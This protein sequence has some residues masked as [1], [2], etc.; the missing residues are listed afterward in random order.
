MSLRKP[1]Y[2]LAG[3]RSE[4]PRSMSLVMQAISSDIGKPKPEIAYVGVASFGDNW[5]FY[6]MIA[7]ML[8][9]ACRCQVKRVK[10][11]QKNADLELARKNLLAADAV[12]MSG[13]DM[14]AG[15]KILVEKNLT[16]FFRDLYHQGKLFFGASAGSIMLANEWIRWKNPDDESSAELFPCLGIAPLICDTHAEEDK[17]VELKSALRLKGEGAIGFGIPAGACLRVHP[18]GQLEA[19]GRKVVRYGLFQGKVKSQGN[20][21]PVAQ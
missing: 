1:V 12:F 5:G 19:L 9:S 16:G 4:G 15:M 17:W 8:H 6:K 11:V 3:G 10:I 7:G 20:L 2:L 18:D 14:E 13:G 21:P